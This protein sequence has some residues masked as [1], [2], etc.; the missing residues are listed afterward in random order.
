M[1][2]LRKWTLL[3]G[4]RK[5]YAFRGADCKEVSDWGGAIDVGVGSQDPVGRALVRSS[6]RK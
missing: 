3:L 4:D 6:N 1:I 2:S 5:M